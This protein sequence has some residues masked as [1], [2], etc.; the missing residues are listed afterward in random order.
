MPSI[1][2]HE[3]QANSNIQEGM[4][5]CLCSLN[6][7]STTDGLLEWL[8]CYGTQYHKDSE[9]SGIIAILYCVLWS[10]LKK[11]TSTSSF[12]QPSHSEVVRPLVAIHLTR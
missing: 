5:Q 8:L 3:V 11:L 1:H 7:L 10:V 6:S 12:S 2:Q 4:A 9:S